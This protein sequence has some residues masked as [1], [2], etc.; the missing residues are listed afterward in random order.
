MEGPTDRRFRKSLEVLLK[1]RCKKR[2]FDKDRP[3]AGVAIRESR[4]R[5]KEEE[6]KEAKKSEGVGVR[7][8]RIT[9]ETVVEVETGCKDKQGAVTYSTRQ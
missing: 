2:G 7:D 9:L 8:R 3:L 5:K 4:G 6:K 1:R